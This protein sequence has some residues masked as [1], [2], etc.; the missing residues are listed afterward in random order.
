MATKL[1]LKADGL[2]ERSE[3][4]ALASALEPL[5]TPELAATTTLIFIDR[6]LEEFAS[7]Q[8][9][10]VDIE[11]MGHSLP[12]GLADANRPDKPVVFTPP[13]QP[14]RYYVHLQPP[15]RGCYTW[16]GVET[17]A[18]P[19]DELW[20]DGSAPRVAQTTDEAFVPDPLPRLCHYLCWLSL[21]GFEGCAPSA[22]R[23]PCLGEYRS[24]IAAAALVLA[25][26]IM[27]NPLTVAEVE[28]ATGFQADADLRRCVERLE[29][30]FQAAPRQADAFDGIYRLHTFP[31]RERRHHRAPCRAPPAV[32]PSVASSSPLHTPHALPSPPTQV[33]GMPSHTSSQHRVNTGD[34][35]F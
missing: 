12:L 22:Y 10:E 2:F 31:D 21:V 9:V 19:N 23:A 14:G 5:L 3:L 4:V 20:P 30:V 26:D 34:D 18:V 28:R 16:R 15:L 27:G 29:A 32:R 35:G 11:H 25:C 33:S 8:A 6:F 24:R 1:A 13:W 7:S 17:Q